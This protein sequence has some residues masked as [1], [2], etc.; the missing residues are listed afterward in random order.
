MRVRRSGNAE[1]EA[2]CWKLRVSSN[3]HLGV[4]LPSSENFEVRPPSLKAMA[5]QRTISRED[6]E[7]AKCKSQNEKLSCLAPLD[8][9]IL[10]S[11]FSIFNFFEPS[12]TIRQTS[13]E[14][15]SAKRIA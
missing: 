5:S 4:G 14:A 7:N 12:E 1:A 9:I 13:H 6:L 10:I 8:S 11:D 3:T 15:C 2:I